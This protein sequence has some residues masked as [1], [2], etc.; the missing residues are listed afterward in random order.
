MKVPERMTVHV[1]SIDDS[2]LSG[3]CLADRQSTVPRGKRIDHFPHF[4]QWQPI[5]GLVDW[6]ISGAALL[7]ATN[8]LIY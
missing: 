2:D 4:W 7:T 3:I 8:P 5:S 1:V 6:W